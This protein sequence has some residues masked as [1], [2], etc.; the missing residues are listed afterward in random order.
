ML[1][2]RSLFVIYFVNTFKI[3][4]FIFYFSGVQE[5]IFFCEN[6]CDYLLGGEYIRE[7]FQA[8]GLR[9]LGEKRF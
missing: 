3:I 7:L 8:F 9:H 5:Y 2:S 1:F 6:L 4:F